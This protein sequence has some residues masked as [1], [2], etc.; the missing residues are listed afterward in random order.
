MLRALFTRKA[1]GF[2]ILPVFRMLSM[3]MKAFDGLPLT[4]DTSAESWKEWSP[5]PEY[6]CNPHSSSASEC[7]DSQ[8]IWD[9]EQKWFGCHSDLR[10]KFPF[11]EQASAVLRPVLQ[12]RSDLPQMSVA[13]PLRDSDWILFNNTFL[14]RQIEQFIAESKLLAL[15]IWVFTVL[16]VI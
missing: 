7:I 6:P 5:W 3:L 4:L 2:V 14:L 8:Y 12:W 1:D 11:S 16:H 13:P 10:V 9:G 15:I